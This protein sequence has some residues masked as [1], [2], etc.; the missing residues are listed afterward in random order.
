MG[1]K[2]LKCT[3]LKL[4]QPAARVSNRRR[5]R[6][7]NEPLKGGVGHSDGEGLEE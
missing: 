1:D 2:Q 6:R 3:N 4:F 5:L 7:D